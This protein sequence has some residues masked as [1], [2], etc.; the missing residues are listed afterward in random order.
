MSDPYD[1]AAA[2]LALSGVD[3]GRAL[4]RAEDAREASTWRARAAADGIEG[5][6][7]AEKKARA[8]LRFEQAGL[9][10]GSAGFSAAQVRAAAAEVTQLEDALL[11]ACGNDRSLARQARAA[12][13]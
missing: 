11:E 4:E 2:Y 6:A 3:V 12:V 7:I 5:L 8:R 1:R 10:D 9:S 13:A